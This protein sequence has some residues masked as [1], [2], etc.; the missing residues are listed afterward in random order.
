VQGGRGGEAASRTAGGRRWRPA[1]DEAESATRGSAGDTRKG[2]GGAQGTSPATRGGAEGLAAG[3]GGPG[4]VEDGAARTA[5][6]RA[7]RGRVAGAVS[8]L[9][10]FWN[11]EAAPGRPHL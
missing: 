8:G 1:A 10:N 7:R 6:S 2:G 9:R 3:V 5:A 11:E 4:C